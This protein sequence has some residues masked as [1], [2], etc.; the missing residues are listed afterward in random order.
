MILAEIWRK[1]M[2]AM[3]ASESTRTMK[4]SLVALLL[5]SEVE[6]KRVGE[7]DTYTLSPGESSVYN[8]SIVLD[9]PPAPA[10]RD[11]L[12][13]ET[14][15]VPARRLQTKIE[16]CLEENHRV[17][18]D[19]EAETGFSESDTYRIWAPGGLATAL[20]VEREDTERVGASESDW[21]CVVE[22]EESLEKEKIWC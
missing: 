14:C 2:D 20:V 7:K 18:G 16:R 17:L 21:G 5:V 9:D 4:G 8:F 12:G 19:V 13:R 22:D 10:A 6:R 15:D 1:N 11:E 3:K